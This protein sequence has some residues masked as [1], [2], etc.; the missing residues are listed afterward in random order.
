MARRRHA[1]RTGPA[2]RSARAARRTVEDE[3]ELLENTFKRSLRDSR[4]HLFTIYGEA[5][6]GKS[7]LAREFLDGVE[8]ASVLMGRALPYGEGVTYWPLARW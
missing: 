7:R 6:V 5:G 3:L 8:R 2:A 1:G 4:A